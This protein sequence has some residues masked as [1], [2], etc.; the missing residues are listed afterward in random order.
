MAAVLRQARNATNGWSGDR[1][2]D[3]TLRV[4]PLRPVRTRPYPYPRWLT[5]V[6]PSVS[7]NT[8]PPSVFGEGRGHESPP[9]VP[10]RFRK[11]PE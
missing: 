10:F 2:P 7:R 5:P 6:V 1:F 4:V 11:G 3:I 8:D 9:L